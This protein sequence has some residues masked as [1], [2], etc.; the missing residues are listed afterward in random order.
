MIIFLPDNG[1]RNSTCV[2]SH[3]N[4]Y[5]FRRISSIIN[6]CQSMQCTRSN[7][8]EFSQLREYYLNYSRTDS[9]EQQA[10]SV[11]IEALQ[12]LTVNGIWKV[13]GMVYHLGVMRLSR[14]CFKY[15]RI[16]WEVAVH[17]LE[18][19][20]PTFLFQWQFLIYSKTFPEFPFNHIFSYY[21]LVI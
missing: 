5:F 8:D 12:A 20:Y 11:N 15:P 9:F 6:R 10:T 7:K 1:Q 3:M 13:N 17:W 2:S 16:S 14:Y 4:Y 18:L 19:C 21:N